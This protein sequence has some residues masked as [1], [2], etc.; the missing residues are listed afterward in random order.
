MAASLAGAVEYLH[1]QGVIFRDL[2]PDNVGFDKQGNLELF[3]FGLA[4][5]MPQHSNAY[6]DVFEMSGAGTPRY[7]APEVFFYQPYNLK[8]D[9]YSF[10]VMLWELVCLKKPFA[11]YKHRKEFEKAF[12]SRVDKALVINR[13]WP[14]P[15]QDIIT[16]SLSS[17][18]IERPTMSEVC[19]ALTECASSEVEDCDFECTSTSLCSTRKQLSKSLVLPARRLSSVSATSS[20]FTSGTTEGTYED[21]S[22]QE[23]ERRELWVR[24]KK[25][26]L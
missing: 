1:S 23:I 26:T 10:S 14:L 4:R 21:F 8:A 9:V 25:I 2:K 19:T 17:D 18:P 22:L 3:D 12:L 5:F 13:R 7:T 15:I 6:E 24:T 11:K 20:S 16:R